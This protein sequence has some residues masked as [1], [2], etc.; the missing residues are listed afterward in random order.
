VF[1]SAEPPLKPTVVFFIMNDNQFDQFVDQ[2]MDQEQVDEDMDLGAYQD[3]HDYMLKLALDG[4][5]FDDTPLS[6]Y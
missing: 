2:M 5:N 6:N 1:S 4:P 3:Y